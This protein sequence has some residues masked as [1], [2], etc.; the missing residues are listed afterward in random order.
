MPG[1]GS[2]GA[3]WVSLAVALSAPAVAAAAHPLVTDDAGTL[4][5][6]ARQLEVTSELSRDRERAAGTRV[7]DTVEGAATV[8]VGLLDGLDAMVGVATTWS[9][10]AVDGERL[11][12]VRGL[13]DVSLELKWR[14]LE[15]GGFAVALKPG[16][17]LPTGD[18][19]KGLGLGTGRAC[20]GLTVIASQE[21]GPVALHANV[22][23][24]RDEYAHAEDRVASRANLWHLSVAAT[25]ELASR[26]RLVGDLGA[27]TN[28]DRASS[29]WPAHALGGLIYSPR[30]ALDLDVGLKLG[31]TAPEPDLAVRAGI[32]LRF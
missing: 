23:Y 8:G 10:V 24:H 4:G 21:L 12:D 3:G 9:R 27:E 29:T 7:S 31:L 2:R 20:Y 11:E 19:A 13:G 32:T 5:R 15:A 14:A 6:G 16:L 17:T 18:A 25:G 28:A 26:L 1:K 22:G 30:D